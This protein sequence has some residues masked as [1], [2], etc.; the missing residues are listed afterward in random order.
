MS[1]ILKSTQFD[2]TSC[3]PDGPK[4]PTTT[5]VEGTAANIQSA[6][7]TISNSVGSLAVGEDIIVI[8]SNR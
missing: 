7:T 3:W 1:Y 5:K 2:K 4:K 6:L 8:I